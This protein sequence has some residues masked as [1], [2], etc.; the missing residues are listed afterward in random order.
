MTPFNELTAEKA[1]DFVRDNMTFTGD[2]A[3]WVV[4]EIST[5]NARIYVGG[6]APIKMHRKIG[7]FKRKTRL[8]FTISG[9]RNARLRFKDRDKTPKAYRLDNVG[10]EAIVLVVEAGAANQSAVSLKVNA[11]VSGDI[12][13]ANNLGQGQTGKQI[14]IWLFK[15]IDPAEMVGWYEPGQLAQTAVDVAVSTIFGRHA[16]YRITE[17]LVLPSQDENVWQDDPTDVPADADGIYDYG[18][19]AQ[20]WIDYVADTGDGWDSTYAVAY[21]VGQPKLD[22]QG[23][24]EPLPRAEV[25]V[26]GGDQVYPVAN[27]KSYR[28]R[29]LD[30]YEA[31]LP[32]TDP[33]NPHVFAVPGNHDWYDSLVSFTRLFCSRRWFAGWKTR[34][35]RSYF[36]LKLP[37]RWWL[38]GVDVQLDSDIDIPQVRFFKRIAKRM[39]E[40]DRII[41]CTAEPHWIFA[42]LYKKYDDEINEKNLAFLD[43]RVFR[44]Q[45]IAVY[46][47]GD[48]HHYRRHATDA[49]LQKITAGGGGAF[50]HPTHRED[51]KEL[52]GGY[53]LRKAFPPESESKKLTW[54]NL[55]FLF[56]NPWF[57]CLTAFLYTLTCWAVMAN[58]GRFGIRQLWP[59][60]KTS[61]STSIANPFAVFWILLVFGG[62]IFFTDSHSKWYARI[63][64]PLHGLAHVLCTFFI[65]WGA[66]YFGVTCLGLP[67][68]RPLQLLVAGAI[69]FG[70]GWIVGSIVMGVYLLISMNFFGRHSNEAF[71]SLA[72]PDWKHFVRLRID[73]NGCLTLFPIG[74]RK[75]PRKWERSGSA[76][77]PAILPADSRATAP[78]LI[79][80]PVRV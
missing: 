9:D 36:A 32:R 5:G 57:G 17:S 14:F 10:E 29:L 4:G 44:K 43:Q 50:L 66:T 24:D 42:K 6:L 63:A 7:P 73:S 77:G 20:I 70:L 51:V 18:T 62:F 37:H 11:G 25:L 56:L 16:D 46:L 30:P 39:G 67:F 54:K 38:V 76:S 58:V 3:D 68:K 21:H 48:F 52:A 74:I 23:T 65:G 27:R 28:K 69:I 47:S 60:I 61:V 40:G 78:E 53:Q 22:L 35:S 13:E 19:K 45:Q 75:V 59:A 2:F 49:G 1:R 12:I 72:I 31:A 8:R 33:P 34:Q 71:S 64:G 26:F 41:L 79:E 55:G 80:A 15:V